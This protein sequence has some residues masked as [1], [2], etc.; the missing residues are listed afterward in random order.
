MQLMTENCV[1]KGIRE[2]ELKSSELE[3]L[4]LVAKVMGNRGWLIEFSM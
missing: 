2:W 1:K 3:D 4:P